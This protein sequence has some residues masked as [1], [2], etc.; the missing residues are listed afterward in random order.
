MQVKIIRSHRRKR[1]V[2]ARLDKDVL[3]VSAP[4]MISGE[5]LGRIIDDLKSRFERK[6]LK[7]ELDQK[8]D[9]TEIAATLNQEYFDNKLKIN[10]IVYAPNQ[11]RQ[12][13][14]CSY[15]EGNIRISHRV[16]LMPKWVRN[17]VLVHEMAHLVVPN[18]SRAFWE[19]VARYKLAERARG[20][21]LAAGLKI[22]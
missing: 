21:L 17:Y 11:N 3:L 6:K 9:L 16:G 8:Q 13:G 7:E 15:R 20:Y 19:I 18:H 1:T 10:S 22:I 5:R 4:L 2:S 14:C 12:F